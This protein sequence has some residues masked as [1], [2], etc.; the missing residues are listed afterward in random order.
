[1]PDNCGGFPPAVL[2]NLAKV[3]ATRSAVDRGHG[4][5]LDLRFA[6]LVLVATG[7]SSA[8][9]DTLA[10]RACSR[11][12]AKRPPRQ[13]AGIHQPDGYQFPDTRE[14]S[15]RTRFFTEPRQRASSRPRF[16]HIKFGHVFL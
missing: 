10:S 9:P 8:N 12:M 3:V 14:V 5:S 7:G 4:G 16:I 11:Q 2:S 6:Q 1:M 13:E 15:P